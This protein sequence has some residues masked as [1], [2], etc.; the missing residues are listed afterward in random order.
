MARHGADR[1]F[2]DCAQ[3]VGAP[4]WTLWLSPDVGLLAEQVWVNRNVVGGFVVFQ[5]PDAFSSI[6]LFEISNA[7]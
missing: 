3:P 2:A 7:D 1:P 5:S 6:D 4:L